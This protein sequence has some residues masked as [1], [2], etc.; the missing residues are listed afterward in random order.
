MHLLLPRMH[1]FFIEEGIYAQNLAVVCIF[2]AFKDGKMKFCD[3]KLSFF[4]FRCIIFKKL[5]YICN[6]NYR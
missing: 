5:S 3:S 1:V 2:F 4:L 6:E